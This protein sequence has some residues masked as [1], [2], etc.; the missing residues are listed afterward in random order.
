M[1]C[2]C[3]QSYSLEAT[4][5]N[6]GPALLLALCLYLGLIA[7]HGYRFGDEDMTETL[8][9]ALYMHDQSLFPNDLYIQT[10]S[11]NIWNE[12]VIFTWMLSRFFPYLE[13]ASFAIHLISSLFFVLGLLR[14]SQFFVQK[15]SLKLLFLVVCLFLLYN[16]NLGG[17]EAWYN[18]L[19]PSQLAK[20]LGL[21]ALIFFFEGKESV[22]L[23]TLI[24]ATFSQP[25]VG[26]Q[27]ALL[28]ISIIAWQAYQKRAVPKQMLLALLLLALT[29][30]VWLI[31]VTANQIL[32]DS[33]INA[34]TFLDIMEM[35][36]GH[37]FFPSYFPASSWLI[38]VPMILMATFIWKNRSKKIYYFYILGIVIALI[39]TMAV[40]VMRFPWLV[41]LQWFKVTVWLKILS[42][43]AICA[44]LDRRV[45]QLPKSSFVAV[46]LLVIFGLISILEIGGKINLFK[47]K[48]RHLPGTAYHHAEM[49][50]GMA[51]KEVLPHQATLVAPPYVTG[52]RYF[53]QRSLYIDYKSNIHSRKY[54]AEASRR[55]E[56][57]YGMTLEQRRSGMHPVIQGNEFYHQLDEEVFLSLKKDG[58][59]H[60]ITEKR[61]KLNLPVVIENDLFYLYEL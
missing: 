35:R 37:H 53:S 29:A 9:Y 60:V 51:A 57:L 19:M 41:A 54:L 39:Y 42:V 56:L 10:V 47:H 2:D 48:P 30:G 5:V 20:V 33:S 28:L 61:K 52:F 58:L 34:T 25:I 27:L 23:I 45:L 1:T 44:W 22:A 8:A 38:L 6:I 49:T 32:E 3:L 59:T 43:L 13:E 11:T 16:I 46:S 31:T 26:A 36:L 18:Y 12:R 15:L 55:R 50:L 21:W 17:N 4:K 40:E 7:V 14:L 24:P